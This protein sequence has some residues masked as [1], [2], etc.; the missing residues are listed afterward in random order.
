MAYYQPA[1]AWAK[2]ILEGQSPLT[3]IGDSDAPSLLFPMEAVFE[4]YVEKHLAKDV[5]DG[6]NLKRQAR[7][8][9]LVKHQDQDW[10]LLKPDLLIREGSRNRMV[11][12]AK[13]KLLDSRKANAKEKY[14]LSQSDFYQ[15]YAYGHHYLGSEGDI[16]LIYPK[17]D[18]FQEA[19][20]PF[21]FPQALNMKLWVLPFNLETGTLVK[22]KGLL[23]PGITAIC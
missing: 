4:A 20:P 16:L 18:A 17:T 19:L 5:T 22:P 21:S 10:F 9:F 1:L 14:G 15:L 23:L 3:G 2:L 12:D 8:C 7:T 13:W 6:F 11:M